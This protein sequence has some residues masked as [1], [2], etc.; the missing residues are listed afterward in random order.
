MAE[1]IFTTPSAWAG[2]YHMLA[3]NLDQ[4]SDD[5][6]RAAMAAL[7]SYPQLDAWYLD[8]NQEPGEQARV[9]ASGAVEDH[10]FGVLTLPNGKKLACGCYIF[11]LEYEPDW[12]EFFIPLASIEKI[13]PTG[14]YP[15]GPPQGYADWQREMDRALVDVARHIYQSV[16]FQAALIGFELDLDEMEQVYWDA[17]AELPPQNLHN[18]YL[19][20]GANGLEWHPP[21]EQ[22][23]QPE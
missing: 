5:R 1:P 14:G 10:R 9:D 21:G 17:I 22:S 7:L 20:A 16:P 4:R 12:L 19:W 18:G 13:Y 8:R 3:I 15:F 6:S 2:G 11:H 23:H